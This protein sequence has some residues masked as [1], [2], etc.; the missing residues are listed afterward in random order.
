MANRKKLKATLHIVYGSL[1]L[2]VGQ[3]DVPEFGLVWAA[4]NVGQHLSTQTY[5][6]QEVSPHH[7][8]F[9]HFQL[10]STVSPLQLVL[11]ILCSSPRLCTL[12]GEG[13]MECKEIWKGH[14]QH[15][16]IRERWGDGGWQALLHLGKD[17]SRG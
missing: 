13:R 7:L 4:Q 5:G 11:D 10:T 3:P 14:L 6:G 16:R 15:Q 8:R 2:G 1:D 12:E 17:L 9:L